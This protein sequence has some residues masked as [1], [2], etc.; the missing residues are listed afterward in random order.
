MRR[1]VT[2]LH[3]MMGARRQPRN[4]KHFTLRMDPAVVEHL[5]RRARET[6][7]TKSALAERYI[8]EGLALDEH[9]LIAFRE[10]AGGRRAALAGTRLD[11]WQVID[12]FHLSGDSVEEAAA[13]FEIAPHKVEACLRY[14][15]A[16]RQ[17]VDA[18]AEETRA[19]ADRE[20]ATW[21]AAQALQAS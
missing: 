5:E 12:T 9:P 4:R 2:V 1:R 13:Y 15:A 17:E 11:V 8:S 7:R 16:Y 19:F 3:I 14:Y 6:G 10:E 20:E 21:R 18:F